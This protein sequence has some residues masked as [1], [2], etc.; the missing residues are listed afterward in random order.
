MTTRLLIPLPL[1]RWPLHWHCLL[2]LAVVAA[3]GLGARA[4]VLGSDAGVQALQRALVNDNAR[5][6]EARSA[7]PAGL[8]GGGTL[9]FP[10]PSSPLAPPP[11]ANP[12]STLPPR[13]RADDVV[14]DAAPRLGERAQ[15]LGLAIGT[16]SVAQQAATPREWG[17]VTFTV[18][19]SGEYRAAKAWLAAPSLE[20]GLQM[21]RPRWLT[22]LLGA[23]RLI[24]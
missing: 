5:L 2:A 19:A 17:R 20:S 9:A 23:A 15:A 6:A 7:P 22:Y 3:C 16:L 18:A 24:R 13:A 21:P 4:W 10:L 11:A 14:R 1:H 8:T 12:F